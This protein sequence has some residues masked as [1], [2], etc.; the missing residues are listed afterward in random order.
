MMPHTYPRDASGVLS[1]ALPLLLFLV[2]ATLPFNGMMAAKRLLLLLLVGAAVML[3]VRDRH[4][5]SVPT[6]VWA[7]FAL[8][9]VSLLW[10]LNPRYSAGELLPDAL[11]P[12]LAMLCGAIL[13]N[14]WNGARG[15][16]AGLFGGAVLVIGMGLWQ[17]RQEPG[18]D[19]YGLAH[20]YGQFS[21]YLVMILPF[22]LLAIIDAW[23]ERRHVAL[24]LLLLLFAALLAAGNST[25]NR[26]FWI[27]ALAV[28]TVVFFATVTRREFKELRARMVAGATV[29]GLGI[30][31][32]FVYVS[33]GR[34]ANG[35][36]SP[37]DTSLVSTFT[38]SER[39]EMWRFWIDR[40][41]ENPLLGIGFGYDLPCDTF[42][43][44]MPAHWSTLMHAHAHDVF[45]N[46]TIRQGLLGLA[47]F[48]VALAT[49]IYIFWRALRSSDYRTSLAGIAGLAL[50][51][52]AVVKNLTDDFFTRGPLFTFWL[53]IGLL[54]GFVRKRCPE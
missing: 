15:A 37:T 36:V 53:L 50:I 2:C 34:P 35:L 14:S 17:A 33:R 22:I 10:S 44:Q 13:V 42:Q 12:L 21:T 49:L 46:V 24:V 1:L 7:W 47:V 19:W 4:W 28:L 27:A 29:L 8:A 40:I 3:L 9:P 25:Q 38:N 51:V 48:I 54:L 32:G 52:G 45:I 6:S 16:L 23:K 20:G 26:M 39:F 18:Y 43:A 30:V 11:Y 41:R 31:G 5:P